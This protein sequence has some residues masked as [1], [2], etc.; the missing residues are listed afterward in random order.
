MS[1]DLDDCINILDGYIL[2]GKQVSDKDTCRGYFRS[3]CKKHLFS[4]KRFEKLINEIKSYK[5]IYEQHQIPGRF[6][7][8]MEFDHC[9]LSLRSCLDHL[10]QLINLIAHLGLTPRTK[11]GKTPVSIRYVISAINNNTQFC[12]NK[13]LSEISTLLN[14]MLK[15]NWYK[16]LHSTRIELFHVSSDRL[17]RK[18]ILD[19]NGKLT[20]LYFYFTSIVP[21]SPLTG[22]E[23]EVT[24]F[25]SNVISEVELIL[26]SSFEL[27]SNYLFEQANLTLS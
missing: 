7:I 5:M 2:S 27:L 18:V 26:K 15:A 10:A 1:T 14:E 8:E 17:T 11:T 16:N 20:D 9:I 23:M 4:E 3:T 12:N 13:H 19:K 6:N 25:C 24:S 21:G 22:K